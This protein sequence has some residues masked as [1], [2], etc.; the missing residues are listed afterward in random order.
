[1]KNPDKRE[2]ALPPGPVSTSKDDLL[3]W[4]E[5]FPILEKTVYLISNS[6]G[7][8]PRQVCQALEDYA[9]AWGSGSV[10]ACGDSWWDTPVSLGN[11]LAP[12][13]GS[14]CENTQSEF[15]RLRRRFRG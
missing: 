12:I 15:R 11:L 9:D 8:M 6:L 1:M 10:R 7:A 3:R 13:I 2:G 4:R 5:E 14:S